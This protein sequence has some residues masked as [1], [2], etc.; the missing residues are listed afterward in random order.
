MVALPL[1]MYPKPAL[2]GCIAR[3]Y[4]ILGTYVVYS[5]RGQYLNKIRYL[6][7]DVNELAL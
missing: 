4:N 7:R 2:F 3:A 6:L 5:V 1:L